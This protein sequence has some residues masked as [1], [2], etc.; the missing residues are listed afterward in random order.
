MEF[1]MPFYITLIF[2][3]VIG[4]IVFIFLS[5]RERQ[6]YLYYWTCGWSLFM[7]RAV[8]DFIHEYRPWIGFTF[9][10]RFSLLAGSCFLLLGSLLF[11]G[12]RI[13]KA[14]LLFLVVLESYSV[15]T[16][17]LNFQYVPLNYDKVRTC[18][19]DRG[20]KSR[21]QSNSLHIQHTPLLA[22]GLLIIIGAVFLRSRRLSRAGKTLLGIV[23]TSSI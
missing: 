20:I 9:F 23:F 15:G 7:V 2:A 19:D 6:K 13:R 17:L 14:W 11:M 18:K 22:A 10:G 12:R 8:L 1:K 16:V 21:Q 5:V 4:T 3:G